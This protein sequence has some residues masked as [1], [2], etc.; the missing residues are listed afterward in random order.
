MS[1]IQTS[2]SL[3]RVLFV[4]GYLWS[5]MKAHT[6]YK[7]DEDDEI[8]TLA[9]AKK[10]AGDFEKLTRAAIHTIVRREETTFEEITA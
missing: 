7:L 4:E 9:D 10:Y 6:V 8:E 2:I 5:G 1:D 3:D